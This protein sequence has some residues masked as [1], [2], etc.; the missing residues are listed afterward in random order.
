M[1]TLV[2]SVSVMEESQVRTIEAPQP[3]GIWY[4]ISHGVFL[5]QIDEALTRNNLTVK[6]KS[7][8]V[9]TDESRL[10]TTYK[11]NGDTERKDF[12]LLLGGRNAT[13]KMLSAGLAFGN[14]VFIC[15]NLVFVGDVV[16]KRRHTLNILNDLPAMMDNII[17]SFLGKYDE[18]CNQIDFYKERSITDKDAKSFLWDMTEVLPYNYVKKEIFPAW[19]NPRYEELKNKTVW[20]LHNAIT[21]GMKKRQEKNPFTASN[22]SQ[23]IISMLNKRWTPAKVA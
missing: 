12:G 18:T 13:D 15:G 16:I 22:E 6:E 23:E 11:L 20:R 2:K 17:K 3:D 9:S 1:R 8:Q 5:D 10:F 7:F 21:E 4:P 14:H 19:V